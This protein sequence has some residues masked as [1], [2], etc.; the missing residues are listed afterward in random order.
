KDTA[1][2]KTDT[3]K[4]VVEVLSNKNWGASSSLMNDIAKDTY[5][6]EKYGTIMQCIWTA[7]E[8][9]NREWRKVFKAL[10]LLDHLIKNGAERVVEDAR[11]HLHR[12]RMLADSFN[13][14]EGHLD[15][16]SGVRE[17]SK[18]LIDLLASNDAIRDEREKARKL[19]DKFVGIGSG[20]GG[21]G[22]GGSGGGGGGGRYG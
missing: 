9:N 3:E 10:S 4:R 16:G 13:Y 20:G 15:K 2:A 1:L 14:Y 17:K 18:Q 6:Y 22:Y 21:G 11:D 7:L 5:D 19:R 8:S 12:I